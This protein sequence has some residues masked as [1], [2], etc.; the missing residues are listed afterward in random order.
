V[1]GEVQGHQKL[2]DKY[3]EGFWRSAM[4]WL[5]RKNLDERLLRFLDM[6]GQ[7]ESVC[8]IGPTDTGLIEL[9][10]REG[11]VLLTDDER[12]LAWRAWGQGVKCQLVEKLIGIW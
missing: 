4:D 8:M 7:T 3:A 9:A 12:S 11:C 2:K 1:I 10:R 5:T 6:K